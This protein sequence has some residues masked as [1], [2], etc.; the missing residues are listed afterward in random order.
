VSIDPEHISTSYVE[1][2]KPFDAHGN[3]AL[4]AAFDPLLE[5]ARSSTENRRAKCV[6]EDDS[7]GQAVERRGTKFPSRHRLPE[8]QVP[9]RHTAMI[10]DEGVVDDDVLA[11][12]AGKPGDMPIVVDAVVLGRHKQRTKVG[13]LAS[14]HIDTA[15]DSA[16]V[17]PAAMVAAA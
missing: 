8:G 15:R 17:H 1:R 9:M 14:I 5:E 3:A 2:Q 16:E 12:G 11:A 10:G 4:A 13:Q 7:E 6:D